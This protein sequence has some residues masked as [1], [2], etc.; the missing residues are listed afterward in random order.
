VHIAIIVPAY[1]AARFLPT[2]LASLRAQTH[3]DWSAHIVD[4]GSS[5]GTADIPLPD[6]RIALHRRPHA[7]VSAARNHGLT[8]ARGADAIMFLDA[9]DWL[10]PDALARLAFT[11]EASPWAV[12][13]AGG[14][15]FVAQDGRTRLAPRPRSGALL[16]R[17]LVRNLFV[18]GGQLLICRE[19]VETAGLF[20]PDLPYGEDW[21]FWTRLAALG[22]FVTIPTRAPVLFAREHQDSAYRRMATQP[23]R[24]QSVLD[25]I[26]GN[27]AHLT[28]L[29][30]T[31]LH[32]LHAKA[33]AEQAWIIG[34]ELI[35][36]GQSSIGRTWLRQS[37]GQSPSLRRTALFLLS[38]T[39]L[40]PFRPY[41][42]PGA[43][44]T[45]A[46]PPADTLVT[47]SP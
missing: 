27:P 31:T 15:A 25:A 5:D 33:Q 23:G 35:R 26:Y 11:L 17:L 41:K 29:G 30:S 34:R 8:H 7:G 24:A 13:A 2:C 4:D 12:A 16:E 37:L 3:T 1:N 39:G 45:A 36:H 40:G 47:I 6:P 20:R 19:A 44:P 22:E 32:R 21:E 43:H 46:V 28:R 14:N 38:A 9:D 18:N 42:F 10:A